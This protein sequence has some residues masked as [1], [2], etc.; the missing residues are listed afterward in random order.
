MAQGGGHP[1]WAWDRWFLT[2]MIAHRQGAVE[3]AKPGF[4]RKKSAKLRKLV[5]TIIRGQTAEINRYHTS[6]EDVK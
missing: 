4:T 5:T 6:L 3:M 1:R 2:P